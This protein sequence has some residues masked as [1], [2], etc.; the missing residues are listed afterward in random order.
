M[1]AS[2]TGEGEEMAVRYVPVHTNEQKTFSHLHNWQI[3][4]DSVVVVCSI[5]KRQIGVQDMVFAVQLSNRHIRS[6]HHQM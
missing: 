2:S 5:G 6:L 3:I 1:K 4:E